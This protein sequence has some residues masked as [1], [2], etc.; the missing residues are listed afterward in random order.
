MLAGMNEGPDPAGPTRPVFSAHS[1]GSAEQKGKRV[2]AGEEFAPDKGVYAPAI[3]PSLDKDTLNH[4]P[5]T[6]PKARTGWWLKLPSQSPHPPRVGFPSLHPES[7]VS[8]RL[9]PMAFPSRKVIR[10]GPLQSSSSPDKV[11]HT[12]LFLLVHPQGQI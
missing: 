6:L 10:T 11:T 2:E 4:A 9:G 1:L 8:G 3:S 7:R 12:R 5:G